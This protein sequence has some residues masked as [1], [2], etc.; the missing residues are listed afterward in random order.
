MIERRRL[1]RLVVSTLHENGEMRAREL[2]SVLVVQQPSV[3]REEKVRG[4]RSF[5]KIINTFSGVR[6]VG[7]NPTFYK[8]SRI[9]F[10]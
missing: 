2:Y 10:K 1:Q 5:C 8:V 7:D 3:L 9:T 6:N 4:F